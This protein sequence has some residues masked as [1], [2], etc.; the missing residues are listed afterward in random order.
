[1][2]KFAIRVEETRGK[3]FIVK[4]DNLDE[5]IDKV[6]HSNIVLDD[7]SGEQDVFASPFAKVTGEATGEQLEDCEYLN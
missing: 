2:R 1:M 3:T 6:K 7:V 4:A 5:A